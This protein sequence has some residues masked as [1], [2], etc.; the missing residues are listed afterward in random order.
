MIVVLCHCVPTVLRERVF[1]RYTATATNTPRHNGRSKIEQVG[2]SWQRSR[3]FHNTL[4]P[5]GKMSATCLGL[6][7]GLAG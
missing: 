3:R 2:Y 4:I 6:G 1:Y 7:K 5:R